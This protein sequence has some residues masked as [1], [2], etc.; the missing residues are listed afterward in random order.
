MKAQLKKIRPSW[1]AAGITILFVVGAILVSGRPILYYS[2]S[3]IEDE[4][5]VPEERTEALRRLL[6]VVIIPYPN[7]RV[8]PSLADTRQPVRLGYVYTEYG[9]LGM[10]LWAHL[11]PDLDTVF[12][13]EGES[14][15]YAA[16]I[17]NAA[18][19]NPARLAYWER[20][21][22]ISIPR[23]HG[24]RWYNHIW[25][26]LLPVLLLIW[27]LLRRKEDWEREEAHWNS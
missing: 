23:E 12:Y 24:T 11:E 3:V 7:G 2:A 13:M 27:F 22:G 1:V 26:W 19:N 25:G 6:P 5:V 20:E 4:L 10:P 9:F 14:G 18:S 8:R 15:Y 17:N 21:T 16:T